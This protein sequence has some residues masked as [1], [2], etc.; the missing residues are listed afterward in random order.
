MLIVGLALGAVLGEPDLDRAFAQSGGPYRISRATIAGGGVT[1][2]S[3]GTHRLG[4]T[5]AQPHAGVFAGDNVALTGGF[6]IADG[7]APPGSSVSGSVRYYNADRAVPGVTVSLSGA[8]AVSASTDSAGTYAATGLDSGSWEARPV[9]IGD[10]RQGVS[11]LDASYVLQSVVGLRSLSAAQ[12]LACD[13]T[14][15]G[16]ISA[17]DAARIMQLVVGVISTFPASTMC[18]SDWLFTPDPAAP[19]A[20]QLTFPQLAGGT[21]QNGAFAYEPLDTAL[22]GQ[23]FTAILLGD[24]TGNWTPAAAGTGR[25][26]P[27]EEGP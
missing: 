21:C 27:G 14:G 18:G 24:C 13:V 1:F 16:S 22:T 4:G 26:S 6:W 15:N 12:S 11:A 2:G 9:K 10:R 19:G 8:T 23:D 17:L 3:G 7:A 20:P 5:A 25:S